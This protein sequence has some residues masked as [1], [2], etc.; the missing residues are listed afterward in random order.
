MRQPE[1]STMV[2]LLDKLT[3]E[4]GLFL[5]EKERNSFGIYARELTEWNKKTNLT[6]IRKPEN[7][8]IKHF[9]DSLMVLKYI[10]LRGSVVD[11][12]SGG[13]FPGIPLKIKIPSLNM[14]LI[15]ASRKKAN[16]LKNIIRRLHLKNIT[17]FNG[18]VEHYKETNIFDFVVARAFADTVTLCRMGAPLVRCGG[19][20]IAM[21]GKD[22]QEEEDTTGQTETGIRLTERYR[23]ELPGGQG[24]RTLLVL[25]KCFT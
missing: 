21:K 15:E 17:V 22:P 9:V 7:I 16:F 5:T 3:A 6:A 25:Q 11:I 24:K 19:Y 10:S 23:Y 4:M 12:G 18:R 13:G 8:V 20:V 2:T 1:S 14:T